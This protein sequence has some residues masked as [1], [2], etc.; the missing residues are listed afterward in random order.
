MA[1][2]GYWVFD[3]PFTADSIATAQAVEDVLVR[4]DGLNSEQLYPY[5]VFRKPFEKVL[6]Q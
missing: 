4:R 2:G 3:D 6:P 5:Y 1:P